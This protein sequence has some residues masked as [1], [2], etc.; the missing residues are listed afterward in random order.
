MI[1]LKEYIDQLIKDEIAI[2]NYSFI[3]S[4]YSDLS[5]VD[6]YFPSIVSTVENYYEYE[7]EKWG[8]KLSE[9]QKENLN[10]FVVSKLECDPFWI[11]SNSGYWCA[12]NE[13][14][15]ATSEEIEIFHGL[16]MTD[17]RRE[18]INRH[19]ELYIPQCGSEY[20]YYVNQS[21]YYID[22][23]IEEIE[24]YILAGKNK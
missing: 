16:K 19:T 3:E 7:T 24:T 8:F 4:L 15:I 9:K 2:T 10:N 12:K 20:G 5:W 6:Y 11:K 17:F 13:V 21:F 22:F 1:N 18:I 14:S 23:S